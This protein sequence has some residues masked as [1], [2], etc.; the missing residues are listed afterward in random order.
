V[1]VDV[2]IP[3]FNAASHL[4]TTI[5]S[6]LGQSRRPDGVIVVDDGSTDASARI[7]S[8]FGPPVRVVRQVNAGECAARNRGMEE[9]EAD[10]VAFLD[11][12]DVWD[13][14]KLAKQL[15]AVESGR[16]VDCVHTDVYV[17][18]AGAERGDHASAARAGDE[19]SVE[20][21]LLDPLI[22]PSS[23]LVRRTI[24]ARFPV[25]VRQGGDMLFFAS[26]ALAGSQF[27][28]IP[29]PLVGYRLHA[30]QVTR[31]PDAWVS[32]FRNRFR[33][34]EE[35]RPALG[36]ER[37]DRLRK[38]LQ[39]QVIHWL[40]LARWNRQWDRYD[41]L[42][43][44]ARTL[45]WQGQP[46]PVLHERILPKACYAVKDWFDAVLAARRTQRQQ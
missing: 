8:S 6:V 15:D 36:A 30:A 39:H 19:Y 22:H 13:T 26:M 38:Q 11:A 41:R 18:G 46:P 23:A 1:T 21:L 42:R 24:R 20:T 7:A 3:C 40:H 25:G 5:R 33:W 12:D 35:V 31:E 10:W 44:Y 4:E 17:F 14:R 2:V 43:T 34:L 29:E 28:R 37:A 9:S 27:W 45:D 32:H 16:P